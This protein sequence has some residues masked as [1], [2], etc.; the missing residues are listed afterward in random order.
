[1]S[2]LCFSHWTGILYL[3][4]FDSQVREHLQIYVHGSPAVPIIIQIP[5]E[6]ASPEFMVMMA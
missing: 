2:N 3:F 4:R 5:P 6:N 1:M